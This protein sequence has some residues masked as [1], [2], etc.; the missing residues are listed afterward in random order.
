MTSK[1]YEI[2]SPST[3]LE[4]YYT[5]TN[6]EKNLCVSSISTTLYC[7]MTPSGTYCTYE[8]VVGQAINARASK[9]ICF[10]GFWF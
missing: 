2:T 6:E 9:I 10:G 4:D 5:C 8:I 3:F 1:P 7:I